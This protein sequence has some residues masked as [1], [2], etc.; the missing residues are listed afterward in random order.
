MFVSRR[1]L[2]GVLSAAT[3]A[4]VLTAPAH[5][6]MSMV[7]AK[8]H[9]AMVNTTITL[10]GMGFPGEQTITLAECGATSWLA[11][12]SP[13][14]TEDAI[15]VTTN[16][17]GRFETPFEVGLCPEGEQIKMRTERRCYVG[18]LVTGEDNGELAGATKLIVSYP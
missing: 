16:A 9:K 18:E 15:E 1:S 7:H 10:K 11:P 3:A 12:A 2:A 17:K 5:A 13:C 14:L 6:K 4:L 8:P